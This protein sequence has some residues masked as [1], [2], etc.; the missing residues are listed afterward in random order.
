MAHPPAGGTDK[1]PSATIT[2]IPFLHR[3]FTED[4]RQ[5]SIAFSDS[6]GSVMPPPLLTKASLSINSDLL[7]AALRS[8]TTAPPLT[9]PHHHSR[10]HSHHHSHGDSQSPS[11]SLKDTHHHSHHER[12]HRSGGG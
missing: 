8:S 12:D 11:G 2:E 9:S 1:P 10:H 4:F 3:S 5:P 7:T 6:R